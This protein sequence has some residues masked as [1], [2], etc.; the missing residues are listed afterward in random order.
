M[1]SNRKS[2]GTAS[3][4]PAGIAIAAIVSLVITLLG[5]VVSA[6]LV[7][8][9]L[10]RQESIGY[11]S[12]VVL[13]VSGA[14]G[15]L[16]AMARIKRMRMQMCLLS[17]VCYF[18]LLLSVTALFFGGQYEGIGVTALAILSGCGSVAVLSIAG[19]KR[20]STGRRKKAYR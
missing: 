5:S 4:I 2:T 7:Q 1:V 16:V 8:S 3:S 6:Y 11:A 15:A 13:V 10:I 12:M 19:E 18:L 20:G 17:G 14:V 9:E